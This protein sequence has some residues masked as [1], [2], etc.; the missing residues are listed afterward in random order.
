MGD[1]NL[2]FD[3]GTKNISIGDTSSDNLGF[4]T[5]DSNSNSN[6]NSSPINND[7]I[8]PNLSVVRSEEHTSE[9]QSQ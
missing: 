7:T 3:M 6:I 9:L 8:M 5:G 1:L 2:D 4:T